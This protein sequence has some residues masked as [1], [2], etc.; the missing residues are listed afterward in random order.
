MAGDT[1]G[2][3]RVDRGGPA[4][5]HVHVHE[6]H[7]LH[8]IRSLHHR[9][10]LRGRHR[11]VGP[12]GDH[13]HLAEGAGRPICC[14]QLYAVGELEVDLPVHVNSGEIRLEVGGG[15]EEDRVTDHRDRSTHLARGRRAA[16][17]D[18]CTGR[19]RGRGA[20]RRG[21]NGEPDS[22]QGEQESDH[23]RADDPVGP[24]DAGHHA[25][26]VR[27]PLRGWSPAGRCRPRRGERDLSAVTDAGD[28]SD[29]PHHERASR[30]DDAEDPNCALVRYRS[31]RTDRTTEERTA[32]DEP[33]E[34]H[35]SNPRSASRPLNVAARAPAAPRRPNPVTTA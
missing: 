29:R 21:P 11:T 18:S 5:W 10:E 30:V 14:H 9:V 22:E 7:A 2:E 6:D 31:R 16:R 20:C 33:P 24:A 28:L 3:H 27:P 8:P 35:R 4:P 26:L 15:V 23:H 25:S 34:T 17:C 19:V 12:E 32:H 13:Q 1:G